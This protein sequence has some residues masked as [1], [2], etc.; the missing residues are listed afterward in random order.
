MHVLELR[1]K[2]DTPM[3]VLRQPFDR[4]ADSGE[5]NTQVHDPAVVIDAVAA[6]FAAAS[7]PLAK[8]AR[9]SAR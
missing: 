7:A 4:Y 3:S 1:C 5:I 9:S 8:I 2:G 6:H